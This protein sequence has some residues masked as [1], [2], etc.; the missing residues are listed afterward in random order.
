MFIWEDG[1][2]YF[3]C[4]HDIMGWF[5]IDWTTGLAIAGVQEIFVWYCFAFDVRLGS[6]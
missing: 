3:G 5:M 1:R 6:A 2:G 4:I